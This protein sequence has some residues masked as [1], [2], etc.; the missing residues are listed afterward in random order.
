VG[1]R[2]EGDRRRTVHRD[3]PAGSM[4]ATSRLDAAGKLYAH[5]VGTCVVFTAK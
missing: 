1:E 5:A 3:D 4:D 2:G